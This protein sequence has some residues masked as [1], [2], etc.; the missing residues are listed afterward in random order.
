MGGRPSFSDYADTPL[1]EEPTQ[2]AILADLTCD[3]DGKI[4]QFIDL[5]DVKRT[6]RLHKFKEGEQLLLR[7]FSRLVLIKKLWAIFT[8]FS[9]T[10]TSYTYL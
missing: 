5:R 10:P 1:N 3:S 8:I 2:E 7:G 6:L 9:V 4:D